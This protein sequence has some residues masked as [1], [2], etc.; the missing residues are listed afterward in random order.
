MRPP[1]N[2]SG[3]TQ[4][5]GVHAGQEL[6]EKPIAKNKDRRNGDQKDEHEREDAFS[7]KEKHV[8]A[9]DPG[10]RSAGAESR[11]GGAQVK[12]NVEQA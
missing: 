12:E 7:G 10:D 9:H 6:Q 2:A 11:Y 5:Q 8:R 4:S 3:S 1:G